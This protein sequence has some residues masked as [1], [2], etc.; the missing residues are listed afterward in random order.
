MGFHPS[1]IK[2]SDI[3]VDKDGDGIITRE[4]VHSFVHNEVEKWKNVY[5]ERLDE[6]KTLY[7]EKLRVKEDM[8]KGLKTVLD[9]SLEE[10]DV[11]IEEWKKSYEILEQKHTKLLE[12]YRNKAYK[13]PCIAKTTSNISSEAVEAA[14]ESILNDPNINLKKVPDFIERK[15]YHNLIWIT[16]MVAE[17]IM[18][19]LKIDALGHEFYL[20]MSP[21]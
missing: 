7:E 11:E 13:D 5:D 4:E 20:T 18:G 8:I 9:S 17:K 12:Q 1:K 16:L 10:K 21:K 15:M 19:S 3:D 6:W 14:V 2:L